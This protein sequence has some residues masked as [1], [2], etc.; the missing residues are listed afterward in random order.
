M[1]RT[2]RSPGPPSSYTIRIRGHLDPRRAAWFEGLAVTLLENGETLLVGPV[3]DQ[4]ALHGLLDRIRDL[5]LTLLS[6][7]P[8]EPG[9]SQE[10][11]RE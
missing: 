8:G 9:E 11:N 10:K 4:A 3:A 1:P 7:N 5:N 2:P 6:V